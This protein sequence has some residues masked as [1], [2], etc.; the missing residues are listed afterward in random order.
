M[1]RTIIIILIAACVGVT[2]YIANSTEPLSP[3]IK[4]AV[5]NELLELDEFPARPVWWHD[6]SVLAIGVLA[7][8][9]N[10]HQAA[11]KA[12]KVLASKGISSVSVEV[13]DVVKIQ[14]EDEWKKLAS[15]ACKSV[16]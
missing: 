1:K 14:K 2:W 5:E 13:Y 11:D 12:C 7:G 3:Q 15:D 6:D 9:T 4:S 10:P 8:Q 16:Y